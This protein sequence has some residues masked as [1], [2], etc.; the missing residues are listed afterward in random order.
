MH[1]LA[2]SWDGD[3]PI[4]A[5]LLNLDNKDVKQ[6]QFWVKGL[7]R[8]IIEVIQEE[9]KLLSE[10]NKIH[11]I[12]I[13]DYKKYVDKFGICESFTIYDFPGDGLG[14]GVNEHLKFIVK[15]KNEFIGKWQ[16]IRAKAAEVYNKIEKRG[17]ISDYKLMHPKYEMTVS[18]G[19][20]KNIGFNAQGA[21]DDFELSHP[22]AY[23]DI[24]VNFDWI[25]A[26][27]R[28]SAIMSGDEVM[29]NSYTDGDPYNYIE[30]FIGG[31]ERDRAAI[32]QEYMRSIYGLDL[33]NE[34]LKIFPQFHDWM[35]KKLRGLEENR[36]TESILGRKFYLESDTMS[37]RRKA[38]NSILQ[39]SVAHA[40]HCVLVKVNKEINNDIILVEQHD[41]LTICTRKELL[42]SHIKEISKI[43][44][45]PFEGILDYKVK[46]PFRIN[47]GK[48]WRKYQLFREVR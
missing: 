15:H 10:I 20:S 37:G 46:M 26:E 11:E 5:T 40:M 34:L 18:S 9:D 2:I 33:D 6:Y 29:L 45:Y 3:K 8:K 38:F 23:N 14:V 31:E 12:V 22:S 43:M 25:A 13:I 42:S 21:N 7:S 39:G 28:L 24:F 32:K 35:K 27:P 36:Y 41:S 1:V 30:K 4:C 19:R 17:I 47:I 48:K 44:L 16:E